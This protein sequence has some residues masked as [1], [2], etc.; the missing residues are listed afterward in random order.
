MSKHIHEDIARTARLFLPPGGVVELRAVKAGRYKT[1]SGCFDSVE[2]LAAEA[3]RVDRLTDV[4]AVYVTLNPINPA[5]L[6]RSENKAKPYAEYTASDTDVTARRWLLID[7]DPKRP[8]GIS[9]TDTEH[10]A[11]HERAQAIEA[12]L[13]DLGWPE[14]VRADSGNGAHLLYRVDLP[15]DKDALDLLHGCLVALAARFDD[16]AIVVDQK[17]ANASRITKFYG[18]LTRK[19]ENTADRPHRRSALISVPEAIAVVPVEFLEELAGQAPKPERRPAAPVRTGDTPKDLRG[20]FDVPD[21]I[22]RNG[23]EVVREG[24]WQGG[25]HRWVLAVCPWNADHTDNS[26][27]IGQHASGAVSAGCQHNTCSGRDWQALKD[28]FPLPDRP[29]AAPAR[30][31]NRKAKPEVTIDVTPASEVD[32]EPAPKASRPSKAKNPPENVMADILADSLGDRYR[33]GFDS[34][35][36]YGYDKKL[37]IWVPEQ[38]SLVQAVVDRAMD[39]EDLAPEGYGARTVSSVMDLLRSRIGVRRWSTDI[40]FANGVLTAQGVIPHAPENR[41]LNVR[42]Y[43]YDPDARPGPALDWLSWAVR[44][45]A[46]LLHVLR[47]FLYGVVNGRADFQVFLEL[48]GAGG[49]GKGTFTRLCEALVGQHATVSTELRRLEENRFEPARLKDKLL[50]Q[51][52]DSEKYGGDVSMLKR[53]TGGD[54]IPFEEKNKQSVL[55]FRASGLAIITCNEPIRSSDY[56]SGLSRRRITVKFDRQVDM[57]MGEERDLGREFEPF[58]AGI[59]NWVNDLDADQVKRDLKSAAINV[60]A[61]AEIRDEVEKSTNPMAAWAMETLYY[62]PGEATKVGK[63]DKIPARAGK[64]GHEDRAAYYFDSAIHLYPSYREWCDRTS[65]KALAHNRFSENLKDLLV[66]QYKL[67]NVYHKSSHG[68]D[69]AHFFGITLSA[70]D[71]VNGTPVTL[72]DARDAVRNTRKAKLILVGEKRHRDTVIEEHEEHEELSTT[73]HAHAHAH[74]H[75]HRSVSV[76]DTSSSSCSSTIKS[77]SLFE[78]HEEL[79]GNPQS[80]LSSSSRPRKVVDL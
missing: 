19:G 45:N 65:N 42:P 29:A 34:D 79:S 12:Y 44:D 7:A 70:A 74:T 76:E 66:N 5:L 59:Y 52:N 50:V 43:A 56:T 30:T 10:Q 41:I 69:G 64:D 53:F 80:S 63:A 21:F 38:K 73:Q 35:R 61:I 11:A 39:Q 22:T 77:P 27:W 13:S 3:A 72:A 20:A 57:E 24:P 16:A 15:V 8:A 78:A 60:Q 25:G 55:D 58:L 33:Y 32:E 51:I 9:S 17:M 1:I 37:G 23:L 75:A 40:G 68:R 18:T 31:S 46:E 6:A 62:L 71:T 48:W 67:S 47:C 36:W 54:L 28:A 26:A 14:P 4:P 2:A 49:T